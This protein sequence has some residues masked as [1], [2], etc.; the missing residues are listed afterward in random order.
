MDNEI[1][2]V[3]KLVETLIEFCVEYSFSILGAI[4]ILI[5][6]FVLAGWASGFLLKLF[7]KKNLDITLAKF[8]A[9]LAKLLVIVF[10]IIIAA[11]K[12]G[13]RRRPPVPRKNSR[14]T[15]NFS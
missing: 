7:Q 12:S 13:F 14:L 8:L 3:Q 9:G 15:C 5:I 2:A 6:G 11:M 10:A 1:Q 4:I